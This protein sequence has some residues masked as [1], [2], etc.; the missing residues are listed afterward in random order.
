MLAMI[1]DFEFDVKNTNYDE[2]SSS[3]S[4]SYASHE[5]LGGF[6]TYQNT[7]MYEEQ[8]TLKGT[9]IC[10]SQRQLD[11]FEKIG[12]NKRAITLAFSNGKAF[13]ILILNLNKKR[14]N[15]LNTGEFLKQDY[16]INLQIIGSG[17][18]PVG[19]FVWKK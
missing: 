6:N 13:D 18:K 3:L 16:D 8:I 15:F 11:D 2:F 9:L 10:K 7:G 1:D 4:F 12:K 5:N 19:V 17:F 14:D